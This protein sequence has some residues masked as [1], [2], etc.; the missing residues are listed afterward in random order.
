MANLRSVITAS[1]SCEHCRKNDSDIISLKSD[2]ELDTGTES[3]SFVYRDVRNTPSMSTNMSV[4]QFSLTDSCVDG[5][6]D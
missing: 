3:D 2:A 5:I 4:S 1:K 6:L